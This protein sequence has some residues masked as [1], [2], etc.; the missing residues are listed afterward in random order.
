MVPF[1]VHMN[2]KYPLLPLVFSSPFTLRLF[3]YRLITRALDA[4]PPFLKWACPTEPRTGRRHR[5]SY[6]SLAL[7][8]V[9]EITPVASLA[10]HVNGTANSVAS[11][12]SLEAETISSG[13]PLCSLSCVEDVRDTV[14]D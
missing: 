10:C 12:Q 11:R 6:C 1:L 8:L 3:L 7:A 5:H 13:S 4:C 9:A 2:C 14:D